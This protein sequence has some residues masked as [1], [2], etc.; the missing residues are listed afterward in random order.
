MYMHAKVSISDRHAPVV[1][2]V[3]AVAGGGV[4]VGVGVVAVAAGLDVADVIDEVGVVAPRVLGGLPAAHRGG[5][6]L[7]PPGRVPVV[8]GQRALEHR[9][10]TVAPRHDD[11]FARF[12]LRTPLLIQAR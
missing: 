6:E 1:V 12:L 7:P 4:G 2:P 11:P 5:H 9:V 3:V 10:L 8:R